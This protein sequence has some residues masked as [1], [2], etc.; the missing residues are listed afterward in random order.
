LRS[1]CHSTRNFMLLSFAHR[2]LY[3]LA[4]IYLPDAESPLLGVGAQMNGSVP[5]FPNQQSTIRNQ[6]SEIRG[7]AV[8]YLVPCR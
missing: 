1:K 8:L 7:E 2:L 3:S 5:D 4:R 6:K